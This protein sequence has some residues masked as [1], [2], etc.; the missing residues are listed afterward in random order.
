MTK[1][2]PL[3]F[4]PPAI[5]AGMATGYLY[6]AHW[7]YELSQAGYDMGT[8][9]ALL[10]G[11]MAVKEIIRFMDDSSKLRVYRERMRRLE[12]A[13]K[14]QGEAQFAS[15]QEIKTAGLLAM[16]GVFLGSMKRGRRRFDI[17]VNSENSGI[18]MGAPGAG[19][20]TSSIINTLLT[21]PQTTIVNDHSCEILAVTEHARQLMG[22]ETL[23]LTSS[24][25]AVEEIIGRKI[26]AIYLNNYSA[27][28]FGGAPGKLRA[29]IEARSRLYVP[30]RHDED[31][32]SRFFRTDGRELI[33]F[34]ALY[35][36]FT[37]EVVTLPKIRSVLLSGPDALAEMFSRCLN[38]SAFGG[39]LAEIA[40]GLL[41]IK[42][43]AP[44]QFAGGF[45]VAIQAVKW[46]DHASEVGQVLSKTTFE[47]ARIKDNK[48]VTI[49]VCLPGELSE[50][51][52]LF[53]S[54]V[55]SYMWRTICKDTRSKRILNLLEECIT[56]GQ[57]PLHY[58]IEQGR[59]HNL[60]TYA[61]FQETVGQMEAIYGKNGVKRLLAA[62]ECIWA[63]NIREPETC[64]LLSKMAGA[65]ASHGASTTDRSGFSA[66]MPDQTFSRSASSV[67]L[68]R[69]EAIRTLPRGKALVFYQ[70]LHPI[71]LDKCPYF[72]D[73]RLRAIAQPNPYYKG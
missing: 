41:M 51:H 47:P 5:S 64:E 42:M 12:E 34:I 8:V 4:R 7:C 57:I 35:L 66:D 28:N 19:K 54:S 18:W 11:G 6:G 71:L 58:A 13:A 15:F 27:I 61:A 45:G 31:D 32:K 9:G 36:A 25:S 56:L 46:A 72:L 52:Q 55:F 62:V 67:P 24:P 50:T 73:R 14:D 70:N 22:H 48:P 39:V 16:H 40:N 1:N 43:D 37:G 38:S 2:K 49:Y 59:K 21:N 53:G 20:T 60:V 33:S 23:V 68:M 17:R 10:A 44:E 63:S 29:E 69:A 30:Q 26:D 65:R 3:E